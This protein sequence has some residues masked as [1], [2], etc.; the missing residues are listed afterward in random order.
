MY[1]NEQKYLASSH[2]DNFLEFIKI[3]NSTFKGLTATIV[4]RPGYLYLKTS[5]RAN[6][7]QA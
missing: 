7:N 4:S 2:Q 6:N 5:V 1:N 3:D